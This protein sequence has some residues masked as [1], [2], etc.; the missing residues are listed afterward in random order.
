[1]CKSTGLVGVVSNK[2]TDRV[3]FNS[4]VKIVTVLVYDP[5]IVAGFCT[6]RIEVQSQL[7]HHHRLHIMCPHRDHFTLLKENDSQV[8]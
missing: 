4:F 6:V 3:A 1:M 5:Q 2:D 7:I 8:L